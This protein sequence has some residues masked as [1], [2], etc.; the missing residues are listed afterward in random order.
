[1][2]IKTT[3]TKS[4]LALL[5]IVTMLLGIFSPAMAAGTDRAVG[6]TDIENHWAKDTIIKWTE[7]G[8]IK[9]YEDGKFKPNNNISRAEF[10]A[11]INRAL[12]FN[13]EATIE[14]S[15]VGPD[16][17]FYAD[18]AKAV[19]AGYIEGYE[20]G[21]IK[22][23]QDI[24]RQ[25]AAV[26]LSRAL[27]IAGREQ[28]SQFIDGADIADWS[29]P[30]I[31]ALTERGYIE[32]YSD[33]S[34]QAQRSISR[35]EAVTMLD[36]AR[37]D[38]E[39]DIGGE[40]SEPE[41]DDEDD[42]APDSGGGSSSSGNGGSSSSLN[43][44]A[45]SV[46]GV[47]V[48]GQTLTAT[49]LKPD[50]ASVDY[51]WQRAVKGEDN[52]YGDFVDIDGATDETYK[53]GSSGNGVAPAN[54]YGLM[55]ADPTPHPDEGAKIRLKA[56][57][58][59]RYRGT[60]YSEPVEIVDYLVTPANNSTIK[61][62]EKITVYATGA[63]DL[64]IMLWAKELNNIEAAEEEYE[65]KVFSSRTEKLIGNQMK[66]NRSG[67]VFEI[68]ICQDFIDMLEDGTK[69]TEESSAVTGEYNWK[70]GDK[71]S[72]IITPETNNE[73]W[74]GYNTW[75]EE[76]VGDTFFVYTLVAEYHTYKFNIEDMAVEYIVSE[77]L[78]TPEDAN[79]E[80]MTPVELSIERDVEK[81]RDYKGKVRVAPVG[82]E[83]LQL[84]AKDTE[85]KWWDIN[86]VGWGPEEGFPITD[87]VTEVYVVA[88]EAFDDNVTLKL[89]DVDENY[90]AVDDIIISQEVA[91]KAR[92]PEHSKYGFLSEY[93]LL[94][95]E[96]HQPPLTVLE[97]DG[98]ITDNSV[99]VTADQDVALNPG[100]VT[101][102]AL[103]ALAT[104]LDNSY[105]KEV[106]TSRLV[107]VTL[108]ATDIKE[109]GYD[110][111]RI[112]PLEIEKI[113]GEGNAS[114]LQVWMY[115]SAQDKAW[116]NIA[117]TG[118]GS[119][120]TG[121]NLDPNEDSLMKAY[122]FGTTPGVYEIK[123]KAVDTSKDGE[124]VIA[125]G[126]ANVIVGAAG[127]NVSPLAKN[128]YAAGEELEFTITFDGYEFNEGEYINVNILIQK[129]E[130]GGPPWA[131]GENVLE[132]MIEGGLEVEA[133]EDG[134]FTVKGIVQSGLTYGQLYITLPQYGYF[135]DNAIQLQD[136]DGY[137]VY[138]GASEQ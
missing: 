76:K 40:E 26:A 11:V 126:T 125:E 24:S 62:G 105:D 15:D 114:D 79:F 25:E 52:E 73:I 93:G 107:E 134:K 54:A 38:I 112:L 130:A 2:R 109:L 97:V 59:D 53:L 92:E 60:V 94:P 18:V 10:M 91:V 120:G 65:D 22:P 29:L 116:H 101:N 138:V 42:E 136:N 85:D 135:M 46:E 57:G 75:N 128:H 16:D 129:E 103:K 88:T 124:P 69:Y 9:G 56:T 55:M 34:F 74:E 84:W 14:F 89:V 137:P 6:F 90:G 21:S 123:F 111:V 95:G 96:E 30:Y 36:K 39:E 45:I 100:E 47:P 68:T 20:D 87:A 71:T 133:D 80:G 43:V 118:W 48:V 27:G 5:I 98:L 31:N 63:D 72:W 51:Q 3:E 33:G 61:V 122:V 32:G 8:L 37:A 77:G 104:A 19:K 13:E 110:K 28:G 58:K 82:E 121:F 35:A 132:G 67:D 49:G 70:S 83:S 113:H 117:K 50:G 78:E 44:S 119:K 99:I 1:M 41:E 66:I 81:D 115:A 108:K 86:K 106:L 131:F 17:W 4:K 12:G 127:I 64:R 7:E 23:A 102:N